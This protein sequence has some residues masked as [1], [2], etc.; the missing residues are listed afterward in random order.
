MKPFFICLMMIAGVVNLMQ[1]AQ[2]ETIHR[3]RSIYRNIV[4]VE[5]QGRRCMRFETRRTGNQNQACI[6]LVNPDQLVFEYTQSIMATLFVRKTPKTILV[7]GLGGGL[8]PMALHDILPD[9]EITSVEIDPAV[10]KLAKQYFNYAENEKIKSVVQ[11]GR[12]FIK[13][14]GM[15]GKQYDWVILDAFNGDYIPEHLMTQEF[16]KE[17][18]SILPQGGIVTANTFSGSRLYDYESVTYQS[19]F[20]DLFTLKSPNRSNRIIIGCRCDLTIAEQYLSDN[21]AGWK[22]GFRKFG[23]NTNQLLVLFSREVDWNI[24]SP[25]LTDQFSPANLLNQN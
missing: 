19:V 15:L 10:V 20:G 1:V 25:V 14:A 12:V 8:L 22:P 13:R 16:L 18:K 17:V 11:D 9:T 24:D 3:E 7:I 4:I 5:E 6:D 2:A 21:A 23:L